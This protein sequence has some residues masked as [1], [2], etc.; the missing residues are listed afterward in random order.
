MTY[1]VY[2]DSIFAD[3]DDVPW[4]DRFGRVINPQASPWQERFQRVVN[5]VN[6]DVLALQEVTHSASETAALMNQL[7][8]LPGGASWHA[9]KHSDNVILSRWE[10]GF[11]T[12]NAGHADALV[13]LPD[14]RYAAD[15]FVLSDHL[16]CCGNEPGRQ[17]EAD[18]MVSWLQDARSPGGA[19]NLAANTPMVIVGDFNI[20]GSGQPLETIRTGEVVDDLL[21]DDSPPDWDGTPLTDARPPHNGVGPG[22]YTWRDDSSFFA[23]S[24]LDYVLFTDSVL[25]TANSF[26]LDPATLST[27]VRQSVGLEPFDVQLNESSGRYDHLPVVVDF[28]YPSVLAP[29]D[30]NHDGSIHSADHAVWASQYGAAGDPSADG[31]GDGVVD[32]ADYT[33]WRDAMAAQASAIPEPSTMAMLALAVAC[34]RQRRA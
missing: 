25:Q 18:Q 4:V 26:V 34:G 19:I 1:N 23:P 20:V 5:A 17:S 8:P 29:G 15:L 2:W 30:Y 14:D 9:H 32:A 31:N 3:P 7:A 28:R 16:P 27:E 6:P 21:Y 22:D 11:P 12:S 10:F 24:V 13:D 33:V